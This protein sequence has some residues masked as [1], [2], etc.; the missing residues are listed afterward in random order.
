MTCIYCSIYTRDPNVRD[1]HLDLPNMSNSSRDSET[2]LQ[3]PADISATRFSPAESERESLHQS[4]QHPRPASASLA[5]Q[6]G[7][8]PAPAPAARRCRWSG[9]VCR[10]RR[11]P[12]NADQTQLR[13]LGVGRE[14]RRHFWLR[15]GVQHPLHQSARHPDS[16]QQVQAQFGA[17]PTLQQVATLKRPRTIQVKYPKRNVFPIDFQMFEILPSL[18]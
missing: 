13:L 4:P 7:Q 16:L 2:P 18:T 15:V 14:P 8:R 1:Y 6:F 12:G 3:F 17:G 9:W 11:R 5:A 10:D